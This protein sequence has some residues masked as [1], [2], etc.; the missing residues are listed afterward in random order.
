MNDRRA[1][2]DRDG[3]GRA[4]R[5]CSPRSS[6]QFGAV[7]IRERSH[8]VKFQGTLEVGYRACLWSRTATRVLLS[9]GS[10][11]AEHRRGSVRGPRSASIG[12]RTS[13][14]E[15][16]SPATAAA[17]MPP[18]AI[19]STAR[20]CSRMRSATGCANPP[21]ERPNIKPERPDVLL[22]LARRGLRPPWC[23][24]TSPG[25]SLHRRGYRTEGRPRAA[26]G[27]CGGRGAAARRMAANRGAT[28]AQLVD[29]MCG[30]GTFLT[31]AALIAGDAAPALGRDYFGFLGWRG[32]DADALG[33]AARG[34]A[35]AP[36]GAHAAPLHRRLRRR[37]RTRCAWPSRTSRSA[38]VARVGARREASARGGRAAARRR[39]DWW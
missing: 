10:V 14:P 6:R 1:L 27:K 7:D 9:L 35:R 24:W 31:E 5:R 39:R 36:R 18:S 16:R 37:C 34:G 26:Q 33:A 22:H 3:A 17:A 29:P 15:R 19:R 30:S 4:P 21:G 8:D 23:R 28:A 25:E 32:H 2:L 20:N 38:G 11:E 12:A 13:R